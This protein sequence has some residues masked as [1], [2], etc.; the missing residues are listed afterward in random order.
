MPFNEMAKK[1]S[2]PQKKK[3]KT[4]PVPDKTSKQHLGLPNIQGVGVSTA[5]HFSKTT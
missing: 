5:V 3:T 2:L 1:W 4:Q